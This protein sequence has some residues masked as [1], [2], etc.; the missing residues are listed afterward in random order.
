M[1]TFPGSP[2]LLKGGIVLVD[3]ASGAVR[4]AIALQYNPETLSRSFQIQAAGAEGGDRSQALRIKGPAVESYKLE[5]MVHAMDQLEFPG[6]N[7][8]AVEFGIQPQLALLESLIHPPS[9]RLLSNNALAESGALEILPMETPLPLFVWSKSRVVPVR[10]TELSIT[11]EAFDPALNPIQA[12]V[13]LGLRV[14]SVGDLGFQHKGGSV[15]MAYLQ[16]KE[17]LAARVPAAV[18]SVFGMGGTP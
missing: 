10:V 7:P 3:P 2:K 13:S 6:Q 5:V 9:E 15:F 11:E 4:G 1:T 18:L 8:G 16:Q 17:Q 14:L 12:K